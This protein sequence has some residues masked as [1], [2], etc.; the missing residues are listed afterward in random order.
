MC[1]I[2]CKCQEG[3]KFTIYK[4]SL[5]RGGTRFESKSSKAIEQTKVSPSNEKARLAA[6][7][8]YKVEIVSAKDASKKQAKSKVRI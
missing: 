2:A 6:K 3:F 8:L 5:Q 7:V 1:K 4:F